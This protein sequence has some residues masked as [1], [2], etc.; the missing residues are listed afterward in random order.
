MILAK[1]FSATFFKLDYLGIKKIL[2]KKKLIFTNFTIVQTYE[3][4][5]KIE[6]VFIIKDEVR[7]SLID[8]I[9]MFPSINHV[10]IEKTVRLL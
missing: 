4:K 10:Q 7:I 2:D 6:E 1:N 3:P 5:K 9:N 8:D